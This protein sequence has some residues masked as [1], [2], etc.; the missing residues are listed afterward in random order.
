MY[1]FLPLSPGNMLTPII[2]L[3]TAIRIARKM[4]IKPG[5]KNKSASVVVGMGEW[6]QIPGANKE[7]GSLT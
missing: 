6:R 4:E 2:I 1:R 5:L 7:F 3:A